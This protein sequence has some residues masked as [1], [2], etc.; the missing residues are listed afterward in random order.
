MK[1]SILQISSLFLT[2][3]FCWISYVANSQDLKSTKTTRKEARKVERAIDYQGLG[4]SLERRRFVIEME[5]QLNLNQNQT[6]LNP[7]LNFI[8]VDSSSCVLESESDIFSAFFRGVSKV[9]GS[10]DSWKLVKNNKNLSYYIQFIMFTD[11]GRYQVSITINSDKSASGNLNI[12]DTNF[13]FYGQIV[14][15]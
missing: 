1:K 13:S 2:F 4:V 8:M 11:N 10:I 5:Y 7:M 9:E 14:T 12:S 15:H 3:V 6:R